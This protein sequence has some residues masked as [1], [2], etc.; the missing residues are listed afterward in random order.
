MRGRDEEQKECAVVPQAL[1]GPL[2]C[3]GT[4]VN[5]E[6]L[7]PGQVA[8][9]MGRHTHTYVQHQIKSPEEN[10]RMTWPNMGFKENFL[11]KVMLKLSLRAG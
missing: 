11:G 8:V 1:S 3:G 4:S 2:L 5:M 10:D 6:Y 9:R 7:V